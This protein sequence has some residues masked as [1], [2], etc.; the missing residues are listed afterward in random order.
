MTKKNKNSQT[1]YQFDKELGFWGIPNIKKEIYFEY[2]GDLPVKV[3]H[4]SHGLREKALDNEIGPSILCCGGSHTW[5]GGVGQDQRYSDLLKKHQNKNV[6]N[7]G[8]CSL[9]L[10]QIVLAI[11]KNSKKFNAKIIIIEQYTWALHRILS[12]Q[13]NGENSYIRPT[14]QLQEDGNLKLNKIPLF[15]RYNFIRKIITDYN[16]FKKELKEFQHAIDL[17]KEYDMKLDPMFLTWKS[18]YYVPM[19]EL[20]DAIVRVLIS[21]C[22]ENQIKLLFCLNPLKS[23]LD[24]K[25]NS[26]LIDYDLPHKTFSSILN[27]NGVKFIDTSKSMIQEH[28]ISPVIFNDGHLNQK[29]HAL[30]SKNIYQELIKLKWI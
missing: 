28:K 14:F 20:L 3:E 16:N 9:C 6:I 8:H 7:M 4:N 27:K 23:Q 29:G 24:F 2:A 5:G 30:M 19:Y 17:K 21:F 12:K 11:L 10:G 1:L 13:I 18:N 22:K 26:E 15:Y 25:S